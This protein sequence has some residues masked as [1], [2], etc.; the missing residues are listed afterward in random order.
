MDSVLTFA[1]RTMTSTKARRLPG[2]V[3]VFLQGIARRPVIYMHLSEKGY[4]K[5]AHEE[6]QRLLQAV[7]SLQI[8][9]ELPST[10]QAY[11]DALTAVDGWDETHFALA[12]ASLS[13][14][15][16]SQHAYLFR[17]GL[18][19]EQGVEAINSVSTFL[20]RFKALR[21]GVD[22]EREKTRKE[23]QAAVQLLEQRSIVTKET[24]AQ[25]EAHLAI[26]KD[27]PEVSQLMPTP[28]QRAKYTKAMFELETWFEDWSNIAKIVLRDRKDYRISL[29]L[30]ERKAAAKADKEQE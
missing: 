30:A 11:V 23:D 5:Q 28:E 14:R 1:G 7:S 2:R 24:V 15:Y 10:N 22:P 29:G 9:D 17:D 25:L 26:L 27:V 3:F 4:S 13:R 12:D 8:P 6:G 16:P 18:K 19:A 21:D 20:E